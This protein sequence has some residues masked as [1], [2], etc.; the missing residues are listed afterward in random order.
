MY[1]VTLALASVLFLPPNVTTFDLPLTPSALTG[2]RFV[3][4]S[5]DF[6]GSVVCNSQFAPLVRF[7]PDGLSTSEDPS[8]NGCWQIL[9]RDSLLINGQ[10][11]KRSATS[12]SFLHALPN[13]DPRFGV[14]LLLRS[15]ADRWWRNTEHRSAWLYRELLHDLLAAGI[16]VHDTCLELG[17]DGSADD[18]PY[19]LLAL[20]TR[21]SVAGSPGERPIFPCTVVH[22]REAL[23]NIAGFDCGFFAEDWYDA[24]HLRRRPGD[25]RPGPLPATN[26]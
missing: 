13:R 14:H 10:L 12:R 15:D 24:L 23:R 22:C 19:L 26:E 21:S 1:L 16:R 4:C 5:D 6:S 8:L 25:A 9:D 20:P 7:Y 17:D 2:F 3:A 11:F 18:I